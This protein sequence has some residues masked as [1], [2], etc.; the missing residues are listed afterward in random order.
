[1]NKSI[2]AAYDWQKLEAQNLKIGSRF[3][4]ENAVKNGNV[5]VFVILEIGK[6]DECSFSVFSQEWTTDLLSET[7]FQ[8]LLLKKSDTVFVI[9]SHEEAI[10]LI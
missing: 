10:G 1:M 4:L 8:R 6:T 2:V 9:P 5:E 7:S 3:R